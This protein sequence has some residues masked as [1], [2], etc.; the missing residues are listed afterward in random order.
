M[1]TI[2]PALRDAEIVT[3]ILDPEVHDAVIIFMQHCQQNAV[4]FWGHYQI[5][6]IL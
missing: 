3:K 1:I 4:E 6:P 2:S 5:Y